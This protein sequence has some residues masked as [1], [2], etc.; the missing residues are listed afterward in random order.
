MGKAALMD[1]TLKV[2]V[3]EVRVTR[4]DQISE[5]LKVDHDVVV[6]LLRE[7]ENAEHIRLLKIGS[8]G[9]YVIVLNPAG[10]QF[11]KSSSYTQLTK[12]TGVNYPRQEKTSRSPLKTNK[13]TLTWIIIGIVLVILLGIAAY[14]QG[15]FS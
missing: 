10:R 8:Q 13:K 12:D 4:A 5:L 7:M 15:W 11:Y 6:Q 2:I 1:D 14:K 9:V 3:E